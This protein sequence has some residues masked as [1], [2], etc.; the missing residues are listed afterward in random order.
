MSALPLP[1]RTSVGYYDSAYEFDA[2]KH[3]DFTEL[4]NDSMNSD[5]MLNDNA[6]HWFDQ[7]RIR[8]MSDNDQSINIS[9]DV[10]NNLVNDTTPLLHNKAIA[11]RTNTVKKTTKKRTIDNNVQPNDQQQYNIL[12]DNTASIAEA[13]NS[14]NTH[15]DTSDSLC[16]PLSSARRQSRRI[17]GNK[18]K[19]TDTIL[20]TSINYDDSDDDDA[21]VRKFPA[22][23]KMD[24]VH[25]QPRSAVKYTSKKSTLGH[26]RRISVQ[27][28]SEQISARNCT[29]NKDAAIDTVAEQSRPSTAVRTSIA[30]HRR[31]TAS[32]SSSISRHSNTANESDTNTARRSTRSHTRTDSSDS[33]SQFS[34]TLPS[35]ARATESARSRQSV[36]NKVVTTPTSSRAR[37]QSMRPSTGNKKPRTIP[38]SPKLST[39]TR[40]S[41][42]PSITK[43]RED[44]IIEQIE[45]EKQ[46]IKQQY[47]H[48]QHAV[49]NVL[50][51]VEPHLPVRSTQQL[52]QPK[53]FNL[54]T[55]HR[56]KLHEPDTDTHTHLQSI[57]SKPKLQY[58]PGKLTQPKSF[59]FATDSRVK[60]SDHILTSEQRE[61]NEIQ[62]HGAFKALELDERI[63]HSAG[64]IGVPKLSTRDVTK[65]NEFKLHTD[66]RVRDKPISS[67]QR[68]LTEL[69]ISDKVRSTSSRSSR[70]GTI[71]N[72]Q[73]FQLSTDERGAYK[74]DVL[75]HRV[76]QQAALEA[77]QHEF[78]AIPMLV[79]DQPM[80][81]RHEIK[82][83]EPRP[84]QLK[85]QQL[86]QQY[87]QQ[88]NAQLLSQQ[89]H[90]QQQREFKASDIPAV[91]YNDEL[92]FK[93][94]PA[95]KPLTEISNVVL[96]SD[97]RAQLRQ[98]Y[99]DDQLIKQQ[100]KQQLLQQQQLQ[101][102]QSE[103]E[104]IHHLRQS[105]V[106]KPLPVPSTVYQTNFHV[107]K[108]AKP[109]TEPHTPQFASKRRATSHL[110]N[111]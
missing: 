56:A 95:H 67:E 7:A 11:R 82:V 10:F 51:P 5:A 75:Q 31:I 28:H 71:T 57:P 22:I 14:S 96:K 27:S 70:R 83:T 100:H 45:C 30:N 103:T 41:R 109:L 90:E 58:V 76:Q 84:F 87:Q 32:R 99:D 73:P 101:Q 111:Q 37:T 107:Q 69:G 102:Q 66:S 78:K 33:A 26:A 17:S 42:R 80:Q 53:S 34:T 38:V 91:V 23:E 81:I 4:V 6:D 104:Q 18:R 110:Q 13:L 62:S 29:S 49:H 108:S 65:P 36:Q 24:I 40:M 35:Y 74:S 25:I 77:A 61:L 92:V 47:Q 1:S 16:V 55:E 105:Q 98:A 46:Q 72:P 54:S 64:N 20:P 94:K 21:N 86:H 43:T 63:I 12:V 59:K 68:E 19:S 93:P 50:Q 8:H 15:I 89:L 106:H 79:V 52:T 97:E 3:I 39:A 48:N 44:E 60:S 88:H 9:E 2:P 85:S